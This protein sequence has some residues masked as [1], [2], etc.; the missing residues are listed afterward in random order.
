MLF[1]P[2]WVEWGSTSSVNILHVS[3]LK[4][5]SSLSRTLWKSPFLWCG[6][7]SQFSLLASRYSIFQICGY[8]GDLW[9]FWSKLWKMT[10]NLNLGCLGS[11]CRTNVSQ[12]PP[13]SWMHIAAYGM[14]EFLVP[15]NFSALAIQPIGSVLMNTGSSTFLAQICASSIS[16]AGFPSKIR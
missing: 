15:Q 11:K 4:C 5:W 9:I 14:K 10:P 2:C 12:H 16:N 13:C 8:H 6:F 1:L 7:P 3:A